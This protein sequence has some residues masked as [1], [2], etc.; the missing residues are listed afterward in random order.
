M[1]TDIF[2]TTLLIQMLHVRHFV[3]TTQD[4]VRASI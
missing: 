4:G 2:F 1:I 3:L